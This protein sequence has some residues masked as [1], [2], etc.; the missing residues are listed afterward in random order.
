MLNL[1]RAPKSSSIMIAPHIRL[2]PL[3]NHGSMDSLAHRISRPP[4]QHIPKKQIMQYQAITHN[5]AID[6]RAHPPI[7]NLHS[8]KTTVYNLKPR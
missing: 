6:D 1:P 3:F 4:N 5:M 8:F 2:K 7:P